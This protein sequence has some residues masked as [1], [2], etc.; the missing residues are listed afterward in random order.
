MPKKA[1]KKKGRSPEEEMSGQREFDSQEREGLELR[2]NGWTGV[3][4]H[5]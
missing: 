3:D 2:W 4:L 1:V 5:L